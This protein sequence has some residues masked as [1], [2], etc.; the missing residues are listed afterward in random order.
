M[1]AAAA[2]PTKLW[3]HQREAIQF[4]E[5]LWKSGQRGAMLAICMGG[6]KTRVAIELAIGLGVRLILILCPLRVV[7]IWRAQFAR[8]AEGQFEFVALDHRAGTVPNRTR[9]AREMLAW[10]QEHGRR[11]V[12]CTN[13]DAARLAPFASWALDQAWG[14]VILDESHK[15]KQP[16]GRTSRWCARLGL[17]SYH[18]LALTGTP[19]PHEPTDIWAQFRFL[20]PS[21]LD[22]TY[23]GF[24]AR[25]A[26]MGG[27]YDKQV[28]DWQN[29]D[30]LYQRFHQIAFQVDD[31]VLDLPEEMDEILS[32]DLTAEGARVYAEMETE[33]ITWLKSGEVVTAANA[34]VRLLRLQQITG[35][36]LAGETVDTAKE[37]LL[38]DFLEDIGSEPVVVFAVFKSDLAAIHR[39]AAAC[40]LRSAELSGAVHDQLAGWQR[41]APDDPT[42]LA[43]QIQAGDVGIDLTRARLAVYFS[44]GFSL[45]NYLQSRKRIHRPPQARPCAFY[46]LQIRNSVDEYVL[47]AIER[48]QELIRSV[49]DQL[50]TQ[51]GTH[52]IQH[53]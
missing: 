10:A 13:Y 38:A 22:P 5:R 19:M 21:L 4:V 50:R 49:L 30:E 28:V 47:A 8:F 32:A 14:L 42:V 41:G 34:M 17:R 36:G 26:I 12:L 53:D 29:L 27:Y 48:R 20:N 33:M 3:A 25:Y 51:G 46:H 31:S 16:G 23:G 1:T 52:G 11:L 6:G 39:A 9:R 18:R 44:L 37:T 2:P 45:V 43:V 40:G 24:R 15:L 7:D 35:G